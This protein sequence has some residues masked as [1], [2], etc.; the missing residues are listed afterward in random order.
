MKIQKAL[1]GAI[2]AGITVQALPSCS[3]A[4]QDK[5]KPAVAQP[6]SDVKPPAPDP[7]TDPCPACGMG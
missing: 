5:V 1:L 7:S 6:G 2:L 3:K 4:Q